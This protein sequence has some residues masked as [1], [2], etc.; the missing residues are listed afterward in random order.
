MCQ[1]SRTID[2]WPLTK[3]MKFG[4]FGATDCWWAAAAVTLSSFSRFHNNFQANFTI[5]CSLANLAAAF[6]L[7]A[8]RGGEIGRKEGRKI[9][10][11]LCQIL[12]RNLNGEVDK[13]LEV[14]PNLTAFFLPTC[15]HS[16]SLFRQ[17]NISEMMKP[18]GQG[19]SSKTLYPKFRILYTRI[20]KVGHRHN[21]TFVVQPFID[22]HIMQVIPSSHKH[23]YSLMLHEIV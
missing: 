1:K 13:K 14:T 19:L 5:S 6:Y 10:N 8:Q 7:P 17:G 20:L 15:G 9:S 18:I 23:I 21:S 2:L 11:A 4:C 22:R 12:T 3:R 16:A